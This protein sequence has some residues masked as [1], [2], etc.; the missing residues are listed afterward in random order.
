VEFG[1]GGMNIESKR[2]GMDIEIE[3]QLSDIKRNGEDEK[4][5]KRYKSETISLTCG[6]MRV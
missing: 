6:G 3:E 2:G 4:M 1:D 5:D